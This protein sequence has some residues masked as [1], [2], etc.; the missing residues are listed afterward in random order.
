MPS[1]QKK[2]VRKTA[3]NFGRM[4]KIIACVCVCVCLCLFLCMWLRCVPRCAQHEQ[5]NNFE[6]NGIFH[7]FG[8]I[9]VFIILLEWVSCNYCYYAW[10]RKRVY[11][12]QWPFH[13]IR[14]REKER[15]RF[16]L[17]ALHCDAKFNEVYLFSFFTW[18][19]NYTKNY[20]K[21]T[22]KTFRGSTN[23]LLK[24]RGNKKETMIQKGKVS[25]R[26]KMYVKTKPRMKRK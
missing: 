3:P 13:R 5:L 25:D 8:L 19:T 21:F 4:L 7:R 6:C 23:R 2:C 26:W 12:K 16:I 18:Y 10:C 11:S 1:T 24:E 15:E 22:T 14:E 9:A 17:M 20:C